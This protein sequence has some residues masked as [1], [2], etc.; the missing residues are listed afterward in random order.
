MTNEGESRPYCADREFAEIVPPAHRP[1][2]RPHGSAAG[3]PRHCIAQR[4]AD[5]MVQFVTRVDE[6]LAAQV[7]E[8]VAAGGAA[9]RSDAVRSGLAVLVDMHR[10]RRIGAA[11]VEGYRRRPQTA[12]EI[13]FPDAATAAMI[14]EEPW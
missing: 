12:E 4:Y 10:R 13:G 7:D 2:T 6:T 5:C 9:S 8:L 11:I 1:T 14:A 3:Q